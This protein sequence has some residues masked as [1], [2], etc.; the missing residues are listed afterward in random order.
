MS[1]RREFGEVRPL[2]PAEQGEPDP[3][4]D[5]GRDDAAPLADPGRGLR[6][7]RRL[8]LV[9]GQ[10]QGD[11]RLDGGGEF[12]RPAVEGGP[13]AVLALLTADEQ[14]G[15]PRGGL[16]Q[17]AQELPQK[18]ILGVHGHIGLEVALPPALGVLRGQQEAGGA[19]YGAY[20]GIVH[21]GRHGV[22]SGGFAGRGSSGRQGP[23]A[24]VGR[25]C[26]GFPLVQSCESCCCGS[27]VGRCRSSR[28]TG[29][30]LREV[31]A[32][33][34]DHLFRTTTKSA[35]AVNRSRTRSGMSMAYRASMAMVC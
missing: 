34:N 9:A 20:G 6:H 8:R 16:V 19:L 11:V 25:R 2:P 32:T 29:R 12:A 22:R 7:V 10:A 23:G 14:G 28:D 30:R 31:C 26:H 21:P 5:T 13:G 18:Q 24:S 1:L 17:D 27:A 35:S 3:G 15:G 33:D 4:E